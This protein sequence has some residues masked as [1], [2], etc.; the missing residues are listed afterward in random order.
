M[1]KRLFARGSDGTVC[2]VE[3]GSDDYINNP[4]YNLD[5]VHFHSQLSYMRVPQVYYGS[6]SFPVRAAVWRSG[7]DCGKDYNWSEPQ[8]GTQYF[9]L[10]NHNLGYVPAVI[11]VDGSEALSGNFPIQQRGLSIRSS[12]IVMDT[13]WIYILER[14]VTYEYDLP[15]TSRNYTFYIFQE[16]I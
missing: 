10:V 5:K 14:Y 8:Y 15:S 4:K 16:P 12:A 13:S 6:V 2:I 3:G 9:P 11:G 1:T 7:S